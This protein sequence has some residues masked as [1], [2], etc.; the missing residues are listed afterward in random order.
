LKTFQT[1]PRDE[2]RAP[3][4]CPACG[5][6]DED[7]SIR[8]EDFGF[9]RCAACGLWRQ[10]PLPDPVSVRARYDGSYLEYELE[11]QNEFR[12]LELRSLADVGFPVDAR[13]KEGASSR[14]ALLDVGC[15]TG[16]LAAA[17][18]DRGWDARGVEVS[19]LMASR[20]RADFGLDI[21]AGTLEEARFPDGAFDAVHA[22]HL[23]EHLH[24]PA[25]FLAE[26][27]RILA[28]GGELVLTTPNVASFQFRFRRGSWRSAIRDHLAL[29]SR[30]T[31]ASLAERS[32][33]ALEASV[34]WGGWPKGM[35]PAFLKRPM[36]LA[37]KR[38]GWGDVMCLRFRSVAVRDAGSLASVRGRR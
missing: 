16:A 2:P 19:E 9:V 31:L 22:S 27:H 3:W 29:F 5:S 37:A 4:A 26:C 28:A 23:I 6:G 13:T 35:R 20:G 12:D 14:R 38:F 7:D 36:D 33:F 1:A 30:R 34:T 11:R 17:L 10:Q 24:D 21:R 25:G 18:R 15:A 32:G 8:A